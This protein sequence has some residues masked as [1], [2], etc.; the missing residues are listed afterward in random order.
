MMAP[1]QRWNLW[2]LCIFTVV[3]LCDARQLPYPELKSLIVLNDTIHVAKNNTTRKLLLEFYGEHL[4]NDFDLKITNNDSMCYDKFDYKVEQIRTDQPMAKFVVIL[5]INITT[6][7]YFCMRQNDFTNSVHF[8]GEVIKWSH[9][10]KNIFI[11]SNSR[12]T[13]DS[14]RQYFYPDSHNPK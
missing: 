2:I 10:G 4:N 11:K 13:D 6:D 12:T 5:P 1:I 14:S 3:C 9:V 7:L 8:G